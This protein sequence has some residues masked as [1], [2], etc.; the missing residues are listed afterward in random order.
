MTGLNIRNMTVAD[1]RV[2]GDIG[3]AAWS[4]SDASGALSPAPELIA[5]V[6]QEFSVFPS[7]ATRDV[8][9][10]E[11]ESLVVGWAAREGERDYISDLWVHPEYQGRGIGRQLVLHLLRLM[12]EEGHSFV[13]IHTQ[14]GNSGAIRLYQ[15]CGF[16]IVWRG[17]EHSRSMGIDVEKVHLQREL[18]AAWV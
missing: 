4:S 5:R 3:F 9:V 7:I 14:A 8:H 16:A 10:A 15:R 1:H 12:T 18:P 6:R 17:M 13:R 2:V 11:I